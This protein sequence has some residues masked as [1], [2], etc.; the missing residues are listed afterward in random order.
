[1]KSPEEFFER[2]KRS[3]QTPSSKDERLKVVLIC[4][5]ISTTFW[6]FSALNKEN[7]ITQINYPIQLE[8]DN[9][10]YIAVGDLPDKLPIEVTGGGWDLMTR[11]FGLNMEPIAISLDRPSQVSY[12]LSNSI[13]GSLAPNLDPVAINYILED[14]IKFNIQKRISRT[15]NLDLNP[16]SIDLASDYEIALMPSVVTLTGPEQL[17]AAVSDTLIVALTE[18]NIDENFNQNIELPLLDELIESSIEMVNVT[19]DVDNLISV[20]YDYPIQLINAPDS[21]WEI[22]PN[23]LPI[24]VTMKST[25]FDATDTL[26]FELQVDYNKRTK[27]SLVAIDVIEK[28]DRLLNYSIRIDS[29]KLFKND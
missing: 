12:L 11:S 24:N 18:S 15:V 27:D 6:F 13:R 20:D 28:A 2:I 3:F 8:F 1:L 14:S 4:V 5:I 19:F 9:E 7:Y 17:V 16:Q 29:V 22:L 10:N 25:S 21:T 23:Y 26:L